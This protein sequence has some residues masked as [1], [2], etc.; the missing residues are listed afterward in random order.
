MKI[1]TSL[2]TAARK[3]GAAVCMTALILW[4]AGCNRY[5]QKSE[6]PLVPVTGEVKLGDAPLEDATVEYIPSGGTRGQGGSGMTDLEGR[7][8]IAS[9]FGEPGLTGGD[10]TVV[11]SK[12]ELPPGAVANPD[13]LGPADNPVQQLVAPEY[14]DR[15]RTR[16]K[17]KVPPSGKA[18]HKF[19]VKKNTEPSPAA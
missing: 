11:I 4:A 12:T 15:V 8:E 19:S 14:S 9:P 16:L 18:H 13:F 7:F 10:Y 5:E 6:V 1:P 3:T 2:S 17:A